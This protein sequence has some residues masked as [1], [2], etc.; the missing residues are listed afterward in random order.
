ME[1]AH[2]FPFRKLRYAKY[3]TLTVLLHVEYKDAFEYMFTLN[4]EA[5]TYIIKNFIIVRNGFANEGLIEYQ[6]ETHDRSLF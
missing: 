2:L 6:F 5:R 1:S 3:L 4:R